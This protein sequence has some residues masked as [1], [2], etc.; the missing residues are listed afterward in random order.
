MESVSRAVNDVSRAVDSA[1]RP[2][3]GVNSFFMYFLHNAVW[4][5]GVKAVDSVVRAGGDVSSFLVY[6]IFLPNSIFC[7]SFLHNYI[8]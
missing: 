7:F 3:D 4:R 8:L 6:I 5:G 1:R 2:V